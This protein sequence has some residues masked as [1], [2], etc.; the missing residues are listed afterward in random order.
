VGRCDPKLDLGT[1][2]GLGRPKNQSAHNGFKMDMC[3]GLIDTNPMQL[4]RAQ[5]DTICE[6]YHVLFILSN[7]QK[8]MIV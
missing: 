6:R 8:L 4:E 2:M 7:M 3:V 5:T 1:K